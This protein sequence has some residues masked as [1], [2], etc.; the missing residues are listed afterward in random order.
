MATGVDLTVSDGIPNAVTHSTLSST[1][2]IYEFL[3]RVAQIVFHF[4]I[5]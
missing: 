4:Y 5:I 2:I 1:A 3:L